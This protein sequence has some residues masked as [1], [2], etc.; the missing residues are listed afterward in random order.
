MF[1][2]QPETFFPSGRAVL[3]T[4]VF[5]VKDRKWVMVYLTEFIGI[6]ER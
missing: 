1:G 5:P 4:S 2:E 6:I 3:Q